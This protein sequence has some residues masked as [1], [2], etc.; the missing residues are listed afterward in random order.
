M[1]FTSTDLFA[2]ET[3]SIRLNSLAAYLPFPPYTNNFVYLSGF[4]FH[5]P[6][7]SNFA[8]LKISFSPLSPPTTYKQ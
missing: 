5:I 7:S 3:S 1:S 8:Y 2:G 4:S 6:A